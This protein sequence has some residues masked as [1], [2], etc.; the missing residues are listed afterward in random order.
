LIVC[1]GPITADAA[2]QESLQV[3]LIAD[4]YTTEGLVN[5]LNKYYIN[6]IKRDLT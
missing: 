2:R 3:G 6:E 1:I 5:A 4:E